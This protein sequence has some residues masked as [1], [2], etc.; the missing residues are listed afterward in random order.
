MTLTPLRLALLLAAVALVAGV[1]TLAVIAGVVVYA[2]TR[3]TPTAQAGYRLPAY[4]PPAGPNLL[5]QQAQEQAARD[6][7]KCAQQWQQYQSAYTDYRTSNRGG[8]APSAPM[9]SP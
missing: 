7:A 3:P 1:T 4:Q 6:R 8:M 2:Q 9:C 5:Q